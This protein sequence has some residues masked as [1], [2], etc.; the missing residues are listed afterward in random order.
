MD[1]NMSIT[2]YIKEIGIIYV[3]AFIFYLIDPYGK[4][5]QFGYF[6]I[7]IMILNGKKLIKYIDRDFIFLTLFALT[8][9]LFYSVYQE[10]GIQY[11][12]IY[13]FFP[14]FFYIFGKFLVLKGLPTKHLVLL[15]FIIGFL[16][17][18]SSLIS[19]IINIKDNGFAQMNREIPLFWNGKEMK[20]T[21][22][23]AYLTFNMCLPIIYLNK[24]VRIGL[25][26]KIIAAIIF[27]ATLL[28]VFRLGSR[29]QLL[30]CIL[31]ILTSLFFVIPKQ[32]FKSNV[33]LLIFLFL[34]VALVLKF[35]PLNLNADYFSVLGSR[36]QDS[37]NTS[38]AGGRTELWYKAI[39]NLLVHPLG[40]QGTNV[41]FA[42]NLWLDVARYAGLIPFILLII[43]T[44]RSLKNTFYALRKK[45]NELL[46]NTVILIF[47]LSSML[48]FFVEPIMEGLV[49]LFILFCL[50]QGMI[51]QYL[52]EPDIN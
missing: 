36:L 23:A 34:I 44:S 30:I 7:L 47:T 18:C 5:F 41:R 46:F 4:G 28:S 32:T 6:L 48:I 40:W 52:N 8:Y 2:S 45:P 25:F 43:F 37:G 26:Y 13:S 21:L 11:I 1:S 38:S 24:Q 3:I 9:A 51:N 19:I 22:M 27:I 29:T 49:F 50:F 14:S 31:S 10:S 39:E 15:F 42:H 33:K 16:F 35:V 20:A 17:S 12:L